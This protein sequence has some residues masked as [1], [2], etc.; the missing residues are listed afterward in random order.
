MR[1]GRIGRMPFAVDD[2]DG[3]F[4][5]ALGK[6]VMAGMEMGAERPRRP[7]QLWIVHPDLARP[8][9]AAADLDQRAI[10]LPLLRRHLV[11]G[12]LGVTAKGWRIGHIGFLSLHESESYRSASQTFGAGRHDI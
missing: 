12:D 8:S 11:K 9:D 5:L 1:I 2:A 10:T 6:R 7:R 3:D 4:A